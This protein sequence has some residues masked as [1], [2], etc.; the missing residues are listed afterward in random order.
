MS[1]IDDFGIDCDYFDWL[2]HTIGPYFEEAKSMSNEELSEWVF[3]NEDNIKDMY[4]KMNLD[5]AKKVKKGYKITE[6]QRN[7]LMNAYAFTS[8][9]MEET[10]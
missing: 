8:H 7:C 9:S 5:I 1:W 6:K 4:K 10:P 2:N 3:K